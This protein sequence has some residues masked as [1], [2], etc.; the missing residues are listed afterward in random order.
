MAGGN[1]EGGIRIPA[2]VMAKDLEGADRIAKGVSNLTGGQTLDEKGA[3]G[4]VDTLL[5]SAR[6]EEEAATFAY[7]FWCSVRHT[8]T[9]LHATSLNTPNCTR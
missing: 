7:V 9:V 8:T 1:K 6:L 5:G 3:E 4:F 2:K